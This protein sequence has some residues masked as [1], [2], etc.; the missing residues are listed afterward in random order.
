MREVVELKEDRRLRTAGNRDDEVG[1][2]LF[3]RLQ[4]DLQTLVYQG[5]S[6]TRV[7]MK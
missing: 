3:A 7:V 1:E 2:R 5:S 4:D 6:F